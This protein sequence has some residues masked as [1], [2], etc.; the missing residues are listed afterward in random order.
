MLPFTSPKEHSG[1]TE[2]E[3]IGEGVSKIFGK[4]T[5][6]ETL[7]VAQVKDNGGLILGKK[8]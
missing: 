3:S 1:S 8:L 2:D 6:R 4:E 5:S 7:A